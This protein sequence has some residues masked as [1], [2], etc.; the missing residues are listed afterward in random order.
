[1][2]TVVLIFLSLAVLSGCGNEPNTLAEYEEAGRQAFLNREYVKAKDYLGK[3]AALESSNRD[4]LYYLGL[5]YQREYYLDSAMFYLK[6]ADILHPYDREINTVLYPI[7]FEL[8]EWELAA[9]ALMVLVVTGD[10]I[11]QHRERLADLN[12]KM[13]NMVVAYIHAR[14]LLKSEPD[15]PDRYYQVAVLAHQND[16][17]SQALDII[18]QALA[19]FGAQKRFLVAKG[20]ILSALGDH[21]GA[22]DILR[23]ILHADSSAENKLNLAAVL[24]ENDARSKKEE[25]RRLYIEV[26]DYVGNL[27]IIDSMLTELEKDLQ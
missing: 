19:R 15:N 10:P 14:E 16:S 4:V 3:A 25:A 2:R 26:R 6:R 9:R 21:K 8:K 20:M 23:P 12:A 17:V 13:G 1:M 11:E 22:E 18:N 24:A 7:A 27:P 5:T